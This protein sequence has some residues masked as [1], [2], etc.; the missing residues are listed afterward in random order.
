MLYSERNGFRKQKKRTYDISTEAYD[1]LLDS[2]E[3]MFI[4]WRGSILNIA[5]MIIYP[6]SMSIDKDVI[7]SLNIRIP[8]LLRG[9]E[10]YHPMN[11]ETRAATLNDQF[12]GTVALDFIEWI[13][14]NAKDFTKGRVHPFYG[15][16]HLAF[17]DSKECVSDFR[18]VIN[19]TF[20]AIGLLYKPNDDF[21]IERIVSNE[22]VLIKA[23][24]LADKSKDLLLFDLVHKALS[25]YVSPDESNQKLAVE[26]EW[27]AFEMVKTLDASGGLSKKHSAEKLIR[28]ISKGNTE[29]AKILDAGFNLLTGIGNQFMIRHH[30]TNQVDPRETSHYEYLFNRCLAIV[31]FAMETIS[32]NSPN[33]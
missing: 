26:K 14:A 15:H 11:Y 22:V 1:F 4:F 25:L 9:E 7:K 3:S 23:S 28:N 29:F 30:E 20:N 33:E 17:T 24:E 18:E 16:Y 27:D 6:L 13:C 10:I 12:D 32:D 21:L 5:K 19:S 8:S 31:I 2:C